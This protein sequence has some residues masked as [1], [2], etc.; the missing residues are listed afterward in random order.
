MSAVLGI[1][2]GVG[3]CVLLLGYFALLAWVYYKHVK[4]KGYLNPL[5]VLVFP[6]TILPALLAGFAI[7]PLSHHSDSPAYIS[8]FVL[9]PVIVATGALYGGARALP[10]K[11][12]IAGAR[13]IL[14]PYRFVGGILMA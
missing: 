3:I 4:R 12:R 13:K 8:F 14:F 11:A 7:L 10:R 1:L 5:I 2:I 9:G 6:V